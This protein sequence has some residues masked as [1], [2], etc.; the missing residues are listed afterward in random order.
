MGPSRPRN[1]TR[2][3]TAH[4]PKKHRRKP[5]PRLPKRKPAPLSDAERLA[6]GE[7]PITALRKIR[8]S[9]EHINSIELVVGHA[10]RGQNVLV[11]SDAA[12]VLK[13]HGS[14]ALFEQILKINTLLGEE[15]NEEGEA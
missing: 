10:I 15:P 7:L 14:D 5:S 4:P 8:D 6:K 13:R 2:A 12:D 3:R 9:L 1:S 11:D